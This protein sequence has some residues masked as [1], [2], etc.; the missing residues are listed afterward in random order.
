M[1]LLKGGKVVAD[2]FVDA[3][4]AEAVPESGAVIVSLSNGRSTRRCARA[5][6]RSVWGTKRSVPGLVADDVQKFALIA[7]FPKFRDGR[8]Y[9]YARLLPSYAFKGELRAVGDVLLEQ[10]FFML[11]VGF[12]ALDVSR[13]PI[14]SRHSKRRL[15][16][17]SGTNQRA[18]AARRPRLR[19]RH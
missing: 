16:L 11:R 8:A 6:R 3:S 5:A 19:H 7:Q 12:D 4:A 10:L 15:R 14:R 2:T 9:S 18:T 1:S 17:P 13:A